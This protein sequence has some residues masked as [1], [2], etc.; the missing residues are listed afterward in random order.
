MNQE[1]NMKHHKKLRLAL[2]VQGALWLVAC[3]GGGNAADPL[4]VTTPSSVVTPSP[5]IRNGTAVPSPTM[6]VS[7]KVLNVGY[8]A[9]TLVCADLDNDGAC[10]GS[11]PQATTDAVGAYSLS[12][13]A[14]HR[15]GS[16]LAV[17]RPTSTDTGAT[18]SAPVAIN[19]GW[20]LVAPLEYDDDVTSVAA[21]I[22][23]ITT[24]YYAR[25]RSSGRNR[26]STRIAMFTRIVYST[27]IDQSTGREKLAV[28]FDYVAS[29]QDSDGGLANRLRA[30][31]AYLSDP[32]GKTSHPA[33]AS[34]TVPLTVLQTAAV[35]SGWYNTWT[36][37]SA[38]AA[39]IAVD[40]AK[41]ETLATNSK[42]AAYIA[43][44]ANHYA[45]K[46]VAASEVRGEMGDAASIGGNPWLRDGGVLKYLNFGSKVLS[47]GAIYQKFQ[48]WVAGVWAP[49]TVAGDESLTL[50]PQGKLVVMSGTDNQQAQ[51][52]TYADGNRLTYRNPVSLA[53]LSLDTSTRVADNAVISEWFGQQKLSYENYYLRAAN[54]TAT[55][56]PAAAPGCYTGTSTSVST[57]F[58]GCVTTYRDAYFAA[59][60]GGTT[61]SNIQDSAATTEYYDA[62][63]RDNRI[64]IPLSQTCGS[65]VDGGGTAISLPKV[66]VLGKSLC[67][68]AVDRNT[69]HTL[70][71]LFGTAGVTIHSGTKYYGVSTYT[72]TPTAPCAATGATTGTCTLPAASGDQGLP[73]RLKL[74]LTRTGSE[75]SGT[76]TLSS[77]VGA[78]STTSTAVK[79]GI[80]SNTATTEAIRWEISSANAGLVLISY[81]FRNA[82]DPRK[83]TA[84]VSTSDLDAGT[85]AAPVL[86]AHFATSIAPSTH[87]APNYRK[88]AIA[89]QDGVFVT[90]YQMGAGY[91][92]AERHLNKRGID[93]SIAA[94]KDVIAQVH[95]AGFQ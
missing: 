51:V 38:T 94:L 34:P 81:P 3:G 93:L 30:L 66:S 57:W 56:T 32:A 35:M 15:G 27:N 88:F 55:A 65:G 90:G 69:N 4:G 5:V 50:N 85:E 17:V 8:L 79:A 36:N 80:T 37:A 22:S 83:N 43:S 77:E 41:I 21:N 59:H 7:G 19:N 63:L 29:P 2:A 67:N 9:N 28:D 18:S 58:S 33:N 54:T 68:W 78:W 74:V 20:T 45:L 1:L 75:S 16:L 23:P 82:G 53:R 10:G 71:D 84:T 92:E 39:G 42:P 91:T 61:A 49:V 95:A 89:L 46:S 52:I 73:V 72:A 62:T 86:T 47:S 12:V 60:G 87:T 26:L 11:E 25:L 44:V 48:Q 40:A 24:T 64:D 6:A 70:A 76:G 31:T 14:G 13:P